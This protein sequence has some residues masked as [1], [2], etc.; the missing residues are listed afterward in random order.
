MQK[1]ITF[2]LALLAIFFLC[3]VTSYAEVKEADLAGDWYPASKDELLDQI[4]SYLKMARRPRIEGD[5]IGIISPHAGIRYSGPIAAYA[6]K[7]IEGKKI[8]TVVVIGFSHRKY[9][10]GIAVFDGEAYKTLLGIVEINQDIVK[11]LIDQ[12]EK[13]YS[14]NA[15]FDDENSVEMEIPF[16]QIALKDFKLVLI[17]IGDQSY[18]NSKIIAKAL[19]NVLKNKKNFLLVGST[20]LSHYLA[21]DDAVEMDSNTISIMEEFDPSQLYV[22]NLLGENKLMCGVGAVCATM[23]ASKLLGADKLKILKYANSGDTTS[24]KERVIGYLSVAMYKK[25]DQVE[26][27]Q[28]LSKE[29]KKR[30]LQ[31]ARDSMTTYVK[32]GKKL[33]LK[34]D[35]PTLNREM[36]AFV[37]LHHRGQLKGCIGNII[38]EGPLYLT[39]RDMAIAS[40]TADTRFE[41]VTSSELSDIE[42]EISV[43]S[44]LE[45][46]DDPKKIEMEKHGVLVKSGMRSGVFLPQ[47]ATETGWS[48]DEFM[49]NLCTH[50]AGLSPDAWKKN[51]CE[52]YVFTAEV[53]GEE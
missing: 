15:A 5:V 26:E 19:H 41:P 4:Q 46:I 25:S 35:N 12:D 21:Y 22:E 32:T 40:S 16:L 6:Y 10:E 14:Y 28:M 31:I 30:L 34:E 47:V 13:I 53:F 7:L 36:G 49:S 8:D 9:H 52:I 44:E 1:S 39:V 3:T 24:N 33:E 50:K 11:S 2:A 43:L 51:E 29:E 20:D 23:E 48:R 37:T 42:L 45:K 27:D 18:E 17:A 38:G